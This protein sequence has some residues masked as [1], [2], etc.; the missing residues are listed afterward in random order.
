MKDFFER[1]MVPFLVETNGF[2]RLLS[3][4]EAEEEALMEMKRPLFDSYGRRIPPQVGRSALRNSNSSNNPNNPGSNRQFQ[5]RNPRGDL[6]F[7]P[8]MPP[9]MMTMDGPRFGWNPSGPPPPQQQYGPLNRPFDYMSSGFQ[10]TT[11]NV[12][13]FRNQSIK[14]GLSL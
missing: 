11:F 1:K 13:L 9:M 3:T 10:V 4:E 14:R 2:F 6:D 5:Q 12:E 7:G 8:P